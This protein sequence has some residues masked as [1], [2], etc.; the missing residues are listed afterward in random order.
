MADS[1]WGRLGAT[2]RSC[3]GASAPQASS[4]PSTACTEPLRW[5]IRRWRT[6]ES[7]VAMILPTAG[8]RG[9][10]QHQRR[11]PLRSR[12]DQLAGGTS[13][14]FTPLPSLRSA[15]FS[16]L[17][18]TSLLLM[19]AA[20]HAPAPRAMKKANGAIALANSAAHPSSKMSPPW[21]FPGVPTLSRGAGRV[22][23]APP[24]SAARRLRGRRSTSR[25]NVHLAEEPALDPIGRGEAEVRPNPT[26]RA[27][28]VQSIAEHDRRTG[29]GYDPN[30]PRCEVSPIGQ[31]FCPN[32]RLTASRPDERAPAQAI[33]RG[34]VMRVSGRQSRPIHPGL[35]CLK[36][37]QPDSKATGAPSFYRLSSAPRLRVSVSRPSRGRASS[38]CRREVEQ[39][40]SLHLYVPTSRPL[41]LP[42][43]LRCMSTNT[44]SSSKRICRR[45]RSAILKGAQGFAPRLR[46]LRHS[47]P[48]SAGR[49]VGDDEGDSGAPTRRSGSRRSATTRRS[50][51]RLE[52][53][54]DIG[55]SDSPAAKG[56]FPCP[57][58][59]AFDAHAVGN[60]QTHMPESSTR[61][62]LARPLAWI[63]PT[64]MTYSLASM[65]SSTSVC[66]RSKVSVQYELY[67][68]NPLDRGR[69]PW[70]PARHRAGT[71]QG[72]GESTRV[73]LR[74]PAL[75]LSVNERIPR[76]S[77]ATSPPQYLA[78][79]PRYLLSMQ[80]DYES[81][82]DRRPSAPVHLRPST[83]EGA[84]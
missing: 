30:V 43:P 27:F 33:P 23:E 75:I 71:T 37:R 67:S 44:R 9:S 4:V 61:A 26:R 13:A 66:H 6:E 41:V 29:I 65:Y 22:R 20:A 19:V 39:V 52:F 46:H 73:A 2:R 8:L 68:D 56:F 58:L 10:V 34:T 53:S 70:P 17:L 59:A 1:P 80:S 81:T 47:A 60:S 35:L 55:Y 5:T 24:S 48:G 15:L 78:I 57:I 82:P 14:P 63:R 74:S 54:C 31:G 50:S 38:P 64:T 40:R 51:A 45:P 11:P 77:P 36:R 84:P 28:G 62:P 16:E 7:C 42:R 72:P 76:R 32:S 49:A 69:R 25:S 79:L 3:T 12:G 83:P 18:T 21:W